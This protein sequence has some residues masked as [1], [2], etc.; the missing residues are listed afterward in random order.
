[1]KEKQLVDEILEQ[2]KRE[3]INFDVYIIADEQ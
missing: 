2:Y 3:D 1:M